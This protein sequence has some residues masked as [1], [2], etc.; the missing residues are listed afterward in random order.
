[1]KDPTLGIV[2]SLRFQFSTF[3]IELVE[4]G[5][6]PEAKDVFYNYTDATSMT[7]PQTGQAFK[8]RKE[9][10]VITLQAFINVCLP[11]NSIVVDLNFGQ[12]L[13]FIPL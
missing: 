5:I 3:S 1:M 11:P 10:N 7:K 4:R 8:A 2:F 6:N 13:A 12:V 9:F